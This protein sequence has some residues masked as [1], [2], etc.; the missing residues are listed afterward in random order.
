MIGYKTSKGNHPFEIGA[1]YVTNIA[2]SLGMR[3]T[4]YDGD[5]EGFAINNVDLAHDVPG[6][7][8]LV[9]CLFGASAQGGATAGADWSRT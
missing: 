8:I 2:D 5:F 6:A 7:D 1:S 9:V 4:G 3:D